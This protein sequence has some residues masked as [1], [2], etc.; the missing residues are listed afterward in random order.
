[1]FQE[2]LREFLKDFG[3]KLVFTLE[4][5]TVIDKGTDGND[6]LGIFDKYYASAEMGYMVIDNPKPSLTCLNEDVASIAR[7][8]SVVIQGQGTFKVFTNQPDGTGMAKITLS[9]K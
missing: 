1:M 8:T 4:N 3:T 7:N 6:L 2:N 5:G 9:D